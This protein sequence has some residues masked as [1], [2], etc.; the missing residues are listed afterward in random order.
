MT[1]KKIAI[2]GGG[3]AGL[4]TAYHLTREPDW[5]SKYEI[6][7]YQLGWRLGGKGATGRDAGECWRIEEHGIH[8]FCRFYF[9][10]WRMMDDVYSSL[11]ADDRARLPAPTMD[12]AFLGSSFSY[13]IASVDGCWRD[14]A[15]RLPRRGTK[16]PWETEKTSFT[17]RDIIL[18][19]LG[20]MRRRNRRPHAKLDFIDLLP[21]MGDAAGDLPAEFF[22]A[23][24]AI[25]R[26]IATTIEPLRAGPRAEPLL[27]AMALT[28]EAID[29][30]QRLIALL[31]Q[32]A[33]RDP[34]S[35]RALT[36]LDFY[37][38][39]FR[40]ILHHR[41]W[42]KDIDVIDRFD[43]REWL[44]KHGAS[45]HT[46]NSSAVLSVANIL[47]A[48][49]D[50]DSTRP[51]RL[52]AASWL[53]W[54]LRGLLGQGEYFYFMACGTGEAVILPLF[55]HLR[56]EGVR[57][58]FF[59]KLR[60]VGSQQVAAD[61]VVDS[62]RFERQA[63]LKTAARYNPL[64]RPPGKP[65]SVWPNQPRWGELLHGTENKDA[66]FDYEEWSDAT[67]KGTFSRTLRRGS[68]F[69]YVVWALP[70]SMIPEVG[71]ATLQQKWAN[72]TRYV[73]TTSTQAIQLWLERDTKSLGWNQ[74][75]GD[76]RY[77]SASLPNPLNGM[78][79]F[80]DLLKYESWP[81]GGP[82]GLV[83][84]CSQLH[85]LSG[86]RQREAIRTRTAASASSAST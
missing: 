70:P 72:V 27:D 9:N 59:H 33:L 69:H 78:V 32:G 21:A 24:G 49:P 18:G 20:E 55:L 2:L 30:V 44:H 83:Y 52:S 31:I 67:A 80:D 28:L 82:K 46:L 6:T 10:T 63:S 41:L 15:D 45:P 23:A 71:D 43:Y 13:R 50:G 42:R 5:K 47:F 61:T 65:F 22:D 58:E 8:G 16:K 35:Q 4:S 62:L 64:V 48:Y 73:S 51:P 26:W 14:G 3:P 79:V 81:R 77:A 7:V 17:W 74:A 37:L 11:H 19:L 39:L 38:A 60:Q 1:L 53:N 40:G 86:D 84:L 57:F 76:E 56:R 75:S 25:D 36:T 66:G 68:D 34:S 54:V 12:K 85:V 29:N